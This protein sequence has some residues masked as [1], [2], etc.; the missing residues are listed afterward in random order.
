MKKT[1]IL[2]VLTCG[3]WALVL[4]WRLAKY[5]EWKAGRL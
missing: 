3:A 4:L 5:P 2:T 1:L